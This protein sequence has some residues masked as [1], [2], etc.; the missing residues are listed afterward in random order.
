V[1]D[2]RDRTLFP[3]F[4]DAHV[5]I[6]DQVEEKRLIRRSGSGVTTQLDMFSAGERL[7]RIKTIQSEDR[8]D[9]ADDRM[10]GVGATVPRG[11]ATQMGGPA[12]PTI[13]SPDQAQAFVGCAYCR[14]FRLHKNHS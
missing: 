2:G 4:I 12:I 8:P 7:K 5:H 6:P 3:G 10:A 14:R 11:H 9:L 13:T 1:I